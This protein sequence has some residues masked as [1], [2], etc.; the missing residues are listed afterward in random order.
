[1]QHVALTPNTERYNKN[2]LLNW[3]V[4]VTAAVRLQHV[5]LRDSRQSAANDHSVPFSYFLC[6][7]RNRN[8]SHDNING[9]NNQAVA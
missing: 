4:Y 7:R 6:M 5:Q 8:L 3:V 9:S 1:M 2:P